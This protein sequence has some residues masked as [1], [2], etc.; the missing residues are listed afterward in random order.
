[1]SASTQR[2]PE[3]RDAEGRFVPG[4]SGNPGGQPKGLRE[5]EKQVLERFGPRVLD[6]LEKLYELGSTSE[7]DKVRVAALDCFVKH[8]KGAPRPPKDEPET[9]A[10]NEAEL[11]AKVIDSVVAKDPEAV[12][13]RLALVADP[14]RAR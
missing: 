12:R 8:V 6:A 4:V 1:M 3:T 7:N 10:A 11:V 14:E 9:P 5:L 2:K 13:A